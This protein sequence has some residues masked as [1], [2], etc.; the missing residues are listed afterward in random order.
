MLAYPI[1]EIFICIVCLLFREMFAPGKTFYMFFGSEKG[2]KLFRLAGYRWVGSYVVLINAEVIGYY[3][4]LPVI[5]TEL[6]FLPV[7]YGPDNWL[8][9]NQPCL[10]SEMF[11]EFI[12]ETKNQMQTCRMTI[13][14]FFMLN[15]ALVS[16]C[17]SVGCDGNHD[18]STVC[19]SYE[20][21]R[22]I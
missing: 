18:S 21:K 20:G 22:R 14:D 19:I 6:S 12:V 2:A 5:D 11:K 17:G 1:Y 16:S 4:S 10:H 13:K 8:L 3:K 9:R 7:S 15:V